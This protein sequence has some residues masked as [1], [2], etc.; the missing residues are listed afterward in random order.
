MRIKINF[1][2][3]KN[4]FNE[5]FNKKVNGFVNSLLGVDNKYHGKFSDYSISSMQGAVW[6]DDNTF[7]FPNGGYIYISSNNQ[8]FMNAIINGIMSNKADEICGMKFNGFETAFFNLRKHYDIVRTISPILI[9]TADRHM[10]TFDDDNFLD[11]L[12]EKSI[13]KLILSGVD[14]AKAKSIKFELF[15]TEKARTICVKIGD[16]INIASKV[17]FIVSGN[18][19]A[20]EALYNMGIGKCT[21]FGFGA[22]SVN[23]IY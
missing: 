23:S 12:K 3:S 22:V 10:V 1:S 13:K 2:A 7:S 11:L 14:E 20:R 5:A 21:G 9:S 6:N 19:E 16:A 8:D 17:M 15:H 4:V 18:K